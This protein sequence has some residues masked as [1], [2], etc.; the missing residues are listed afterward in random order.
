MDPVT[1]VGLAASIAQ[2]ITVTTTIIQYLSSIKNAP[3]D[4]AQLIREASSLL[5]V[6]TDLNYT[7]EGADTIESWLGTV[8]SQGLK[9]VLDQLHRSLAG[10][11]EKLEPEHGIKKLGR[12]LVSTLDKNEILDTLAKMERVKSLAGLALHRDR[13]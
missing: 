5:A 8:Y 3:K 1:A 7:L 4:R 12:R 2:L 13:M 11:A 10:L 6:L 9:E